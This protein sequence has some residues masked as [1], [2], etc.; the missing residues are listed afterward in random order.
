MT[1]SSTLYFRKLPSGGF[2]RIDGYEFADDDFRAVLRV[3]RRGD[4]SRRFGHPPP[5]IF[6]T[7]GSCKE[8]VLEQL[9][10]I[11]HD[12][13]MLASAIMRWQST[14]GSEEFSGF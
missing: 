10:A 11:A 12:N 14:S 1:D 5:I 2:V 13:V 7:R 3:E 4:T 9:L 6:E 8:D